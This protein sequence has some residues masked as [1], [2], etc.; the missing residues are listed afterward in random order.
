[1]LSSVDIGEA[2]AADLSAGGKSAL[3]VAAM[4]SAR[5]PT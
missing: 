1:M 4:T 5:R 3:D 2:G